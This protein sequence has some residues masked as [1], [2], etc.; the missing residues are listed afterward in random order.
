MIMITKSNA[1]IVRIVAIILIKVAKKISRTDTRVP[2]DT[3]NDQFTIFVI[4]SM[5]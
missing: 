3:F 4:F 1:M 2:I 5:I